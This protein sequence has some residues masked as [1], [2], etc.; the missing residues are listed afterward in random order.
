MIISV[1]IRK[2]AGT[3]FKQGLFEYFNERVLIDYGDEIGSSWPGSVA[4]RRVRLL[5]AKQKEPQILQDYDFIHG[6]FY[7]TKYDFL[8]VKKRYITFMRDPV[9]RLLSNYFYIK[10]HPGR[11]NLDGII[12]HEKGYSLAEFAAHPDNQNQQYQYLQ[13]ADL[14]EFDFVGLV[15][16]YPSSI[17]KLNAVLGIDVPV[18]ERVNV[19]A[20]AASQYDVD[21]KTLDIIKQNNK[22]DQALYDLALARFHSA[23]HLLRT[24]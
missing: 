21:G 1:H 22:I 12:V 11:K 20:D 3:T 2:C 8:N 14:T 4:K 23:S 6:H 15:E 16:E 5:E 7:R 13:S 10:R 24:N 9:Q 19:N 18:I 17:Q